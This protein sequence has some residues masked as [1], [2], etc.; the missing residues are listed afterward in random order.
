[1][2]KTIL[3]IEDNLEIREGT[4]EV[5]ELTGDY[6][7]LTAPDGKKGV[8]MALKHLPDLILCDIMM[9]E[10]DGYGVLYMLTKNEVTADIPFIFLT[11][12]TERSDLRKAME[13]G[14]DDY[15]T[16]PFDDIELLNAIESRL[17]KREKLALKAR[18][19]NPVQFTEEE[20]EVL[21]HG[22]VKDVRVKNFKKK[23]AIYESG[24]TPVFIYFLVKGRA[25]SFLFYQDGRE[26]STDIY[27]D[28]NFFGYEA[29]LLNEKYSDNVTAL[30]DCEVALV[31]KEKFFDLMYDKPV[32]VR[33][34]IQLLSGNIR[35]KE[36]QML[37]FAYDTVRKRVANALV[38]IAE[39]S[40]ETPDGDEALIRIS[41]D[42]LAALAGTAN[43]TISRMLADFKDEH[44]I[45]K[46]GNA[47]RIASINKLKSIK[48]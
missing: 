42:D 28:S 48:F 47:I 14:A 44:L 2:A 13:M 20:Q 45:T 26:L 4:A 23:Q 38:N 16:K 37:G 34:F 21:L 8:D 35:D 19:K 7:V 12:K 39:K 36:G 31:P 22:L 11:A 1:M 29:V 46:E 5:L 27:V 3:I 40:V 10:L 24:D 25:R 9:P 17:R 43:E 41:R 6:T 18:P 33:K 32:I 15:L 30:E